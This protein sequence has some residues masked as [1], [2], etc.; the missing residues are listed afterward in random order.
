MSEIIVNIF[1]K[2][3]YPIRMDTLNDNVYQPETTTEA[4][5]LCPS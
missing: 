5:F 3:H 1:S 4:T 2:E